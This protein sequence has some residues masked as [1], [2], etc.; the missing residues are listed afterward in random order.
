MGIKM[1]V[2]E[3]T[4]Y[5]G[6]FDKNSCKPG[7]NLTVEKFVCN[8]VMSLQ[9][10]VDKSFLDFTTNTVER[11]NLDMDACLAFEQTLLGMPRFKNNNDFVQPTPTERNERTAAF[12]QYKNKL[13]HARLD[14]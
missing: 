7:T 11:L 10:K 3:I 2:E 12:T 8:K 14:Q 5:F 1:I 6:N 9:E 13:T 4:S